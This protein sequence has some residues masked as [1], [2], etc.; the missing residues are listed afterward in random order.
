[1]TAIARIKTELRKL[2]YGAASVASKY[3][4]AD[5]LSEGAPLREVALAA[6]TDTPTSYRNAAFGVIELQ[7]NP[8]TDILNMRALGA[9]I[10]LCISSDKVE[11]WKISNSNQPICADVRPLSEIEALFIANKEHWVPDRIHSAKFAGIWDLP[12]QLSFVDLGLLRDIE[13]CT[14]ENLDRV[15][16][17]TLKAMVSPEKNSPEDFKGAYRIC[18]YFLAA[19]ILHDRQHKVS[20]NWNFDDAQSVLN[21]IQSHYKLKYLPER[22][23][24][25]SKKCIRSAWEILKNEVSFANISADDLAFVYENTLVSPET[26]KSLGT[27]STPR[28]VA[29]FL[30][31]RLQIGSA[32]DKS[33]KIYEPFCGSGVLS[34]AALSALKGNLPRDWSA[35]KRH[36]FLVKHLRASDI[37]PFACEVASLSF[38]LAD[39]PCANGWDIRQ[40]DLFS[41]KNLA[42]QLEPGMIVVCNPP[43]E[44]FDF[45]ERA[46]YPDES[47]LSIHKPISVIKQ[48]LTSKPEAIGFVMPHAAISGEKYT[49][50]RK[51]LEEYFDEIETVALPDRVFVE[52][53]VESSLVVGRTPRKRNDFSVTQLS[54]ASIKDSERESFLEGMFRPVFRRRRKVSNAGFNGELWVT[55]YDELWEF[56]A[57]Y[58]KLGEFVEFHRGIEWQSGYQAKASSNTKKE[59]YRLGIHSSKYLMQFQLPQPVYLDCREKVLRGGALDNHPWNK[60]KVVLNAARKSRGAWRLAASTDREGLVLSQQLIGCWLKESSQARLQVVEAILNSP[61]ASAFVSGIN[62]RKRFNLRTIE[63][64]PVPRNIDAEQISI[65]TNEICELSGTLEMMLPERERKIK[66]RVLALDSIILSAYG[67]PPRLERKL[68]VSY[69]NQNRPVNFDFSGYPVS[70]SGMAMSLQECLSGRFE[71]N[72]SEWVRELFKPLPKEERDM[73]VN[74][75]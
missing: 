67:L 33:P 14:Q 41:R 24:T 2:G 1:M 48:I 12:T 6:F 20:R 66:D 46:R 56:L 58:P 25:I 57:T 3:Q 53:Q 49:E 71:K 43:F 42:D 38:V 45:E 39:Y 40:A 64:I 68:L 15:I 5:I 27:H 19:K 74:Y 23:H 11:V 51:C 65:L 44:D 75:L 35:S 22:K 31:S 60:P 52:S 62:S 55:E 16:R 63:N 59:G 13:H 37:D 69:H 50:L 54:S 72:R 17:N 21:I 47:T 7:A 8:A 34:V 73:V 18:F 70:H 10:W 4:F 28:S 29:E 61:I 32:S 30:V 36:N 9:P 26:R